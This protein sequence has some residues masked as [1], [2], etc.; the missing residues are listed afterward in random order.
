MVS[1]RVS[2]LVTALVCNEIH[3]TCMTVASLR[4]PV[5]VVFPLLQSA[6]PTESQT[7]ELGRN[8]WGGVL[9]CP[10]LGKPVATEN[11]A[12]AFLYE[13]M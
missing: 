1:C 5:Q 4:F 11:A 12:E 7:R 13:A 2:R 9:S 6:R 3:A 10:C 8:P